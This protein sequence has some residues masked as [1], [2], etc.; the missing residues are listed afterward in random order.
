MWIA[1]EDAAAWRRVSIAFGRAAALFTLITNRQFVLDP[2]ARLNAR[3][4]P[5]GFFLSITLRTSNAKRNVKRSGAS[6]KCW[7]SIPVGTT[8]ETECDTQNTSSAVLRLIAA[9]ESVL[10]VQTS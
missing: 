6:P 4:K 7:R 3:I 5:R 10:G 8:G 9:C 2:N 1:G